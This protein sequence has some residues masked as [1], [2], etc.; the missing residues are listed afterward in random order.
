MTPAYNAPATGADMGDITEG[1]GGAVEGALAGRTVEPRHGENT[2]E[3]GNGTCLNCGASPVGRYC[4]NCGQRSEIHRSLT[5]ILHDIM[6]GVLHLDGKL[7]HTLPLL[8]LKPGALTRRYIE[9]ER[10]KFVSPMAIFL[11]SVF[12]MF[13]VFQMVGLTTPSNVD[14]P[15]SVT[16]NITQ[17]RE[18]AEKELADQRKLVETMSPDDPQYPSALD[19][20]KNREDAVQQLKAVDEFKLD[21]KGQMTLNPTGIKALD[22]GLVKKWRENPGLMLYKLQANAY[23]FSWLLIPISIPFVWLLFAWRRRFKA[24][25]HAIFVTYSIAFMSMLFIALSVLNTLNLVGDWIFLSLVLIPPIHIYR[26]L[27]GAYDL[28]RFSALWRLAV[29]SVMILLVLTIF[30]WLL[31]LLGAA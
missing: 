24:Y 25:D 18:Q 11:F 27:R 23:K 1:L 26:Q 7:W 16:T 13:A 3:H 31:L 29:M 20:L 4:H 8:A 10:A 12:L 2:G 28:S 5:A 30:L 9:G 17:A 6:H 19:R 14:A 21:S 22:E 15:A